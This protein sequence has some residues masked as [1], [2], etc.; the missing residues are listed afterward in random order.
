MVAVAGFST[1]NP[2]AQKAL[3]DNPDRVLTY[4]KSPFY[5][6]FSPTVAQLY[7][8]GEHGEPVLRFSGDIAKVVF[9]AETFAD[10]NDTE[11]INYTDGDVGDGAQPFP[12]DEVMF[13]PN[14]PPSISVD[15]EF[16]VE[17]QQ[18]LVAK[19][20]FTE[21]FT[22]PQEP[23]LVDLE[24]KTA[25]DAKVLPPE[26][27]NDIPIVVV[28]TTPAAYITTD[29]ERSEYDMVEP[30][31]NYL[32]LAEAE[33]PRESEYDAGLSLD[34]EMFADEER[35]VGADGVERDTP[36]AREAS[37][38]GKSVTERL[39]D[40]SGGQLQFSSDEL[41]DRLEVTDEQLEELVEAEKELETATMDDFD[42]A[43]ASQYAKAGLDKI[44]ARGRDIG[45]VR[46]QDVRDRDVRDGA[47]MQPDEDS[48]EGS[49][50][51]DKSSGVSATD[52]KRDSIERA[53]EQV[54]ERDD[55]ERDDVEQ[56]GAEQDGAEI[57]VDQIDLDDLD[58]DDFDGEVDIEL[59]G[60]A[61]E[62]EIPQDDEYGDDE[63]EADGAEVDGAEADGVDTRESDN[64]D[65]GKTTT[66]AA[67]HKETPVSRRVREQQR[68]TRERE[69]RESQNQQDT[70]LDR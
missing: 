57:D 16:S 51:T 30:I 28:D 64:K 54:A 42:K 5:V 41:L 61:L 69:M 22:L 56:D 39:Y 59:D 32:E 65:R 15:Y 52:T 35:E 3:R 66:P 50:L 29:F 49:T 70:G 60:T 67:H 26:D 45:D 62:I 2:Q 12:F 20:Y 1:L 4:D 58:F 8:R 40:L 9:D 13:D 33:T 55:A 19:G 38:R 7:R 46:D 21:S 18:D 24:F 47:S 44:A 68:R 31:P 34:N 36:R 23:Y 10:T 25:L 43:I 11:G 17:Q 48:R 27:D 6:V 53:V 14:M 37:R 63:R